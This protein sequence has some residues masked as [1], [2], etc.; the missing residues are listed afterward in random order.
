LVCPYAPAVELAMDEQGCMHLLGRQ[1][2]AEVGSLLTVAAW[3]RHHLGLLR[4]ALDPV[5]PEG[6]SV[7]HLFTDDA[8]RVR[9]LGDSPVRL[10]LLARVQAGSGATWFSAPL[11]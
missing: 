2:M 4:M 9:T 7:L 6:T 3:V 11:N 10:H 5:Q 1:E 8:R